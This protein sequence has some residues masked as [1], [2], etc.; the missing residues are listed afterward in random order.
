MGIRSR[1]I[2]IMGLFSFIAT[3]IIG[4]ASY[5][6]TE[7]NAIHEARNKG[8]LLFNY[9]ISARKYFKDEQRALFMELVEDNRFYPELMSG[10][11]VSRGV[12]DIFK[13]KNSGYQFKQASLD[14]LYQ[15]NKA[16]KEEVKMINTLQTRPDAHSL[17]GTMSKDGEKYF[18]MAF[19]IKVENKKCLRCHGDPANA[20]KDQIEIYGT[21]NGYNWKYGE[22]VSAYIVYVS[23]QEAVSAAKRT[24]GLLFLIGIGCFFLSLLAMGFFLDRSVIGPIEYL[25]DRTEE[26]SKGRNL[27]EKFICKS[28]DEIG[29]LARAIEHLRQV[30]IKKIKR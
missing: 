4:V 22:I 6:L 20:P 14:P 19:P 10:F 3:V 26:I 15:A 12:W 21:E 8:Q 5:K 28:N 13:E 7:R 9:I 2:F 18:Y 17:Q 30:M 1:M 16:D 24:A 25:S 27:E 11:V 29:V 23:I